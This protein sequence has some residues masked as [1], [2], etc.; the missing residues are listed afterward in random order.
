MAV[1]PG[2]TELT[3]PYWDAA[4]EGRLVVQECRSCHQ[5]QHP[6]LPRCPHCHAADPGWRQVRGDG[7]IY[8][9]TIMHR[10]PS[11]QFPV[12][13]ALAVVDL[14]EGYSMFTSLISDEP[15]TWRIGDAVAVRFVAQPSGIHLP[16]FG[17]DA[18]SAGSVAL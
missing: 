7:T 17:P 11:P 16:F 13:S 10:P 9:Y 12:P 6:P 1:V 3:A 2:M 14:A 18:P 4:R 5:V 8:T 15:V